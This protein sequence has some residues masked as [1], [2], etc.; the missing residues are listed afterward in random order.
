[1]ARAHWT[2]LAELDLEEILYYI[3]VESG[4]PLT[5]GRIGQLVRETCDKLAASPMLGEAA[6]ELGAGLRLFSFKR[7]AIIYRPSDRGI[8]VIGVVDGARDFGDYFR[9]R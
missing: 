4:R 6:P 7:W 2:A 5:A 3:A 1:M 9:F 8:D